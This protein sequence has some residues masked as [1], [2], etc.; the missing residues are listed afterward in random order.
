M[1]KE[2]KRLEPGQR[3]A[4][5]EVYRE[6]KPRSSQ[7]HWLRGQ[8]ASK[9]RR[10]PWRQTGEADWC[11]FVTS[12]LNPWFWTCPKPDHK[13]AILEKS[14]H[15]IYINTGHYFFFKRWW[16]IYFV[17]VF[18]K[19]SAFKIL[20]NQ[21]T[22]VK[23]STK[24]INVSKPQGGSRERDAKN[25]IDCRLCLKAFQDHLLKSLTISPKF[26]PY[27]T[28]HAYSYHKHLLTIFFHGNKYPEVKLLGNI[29]LTIQPKTANIFSRVPI[30]FYT[31]TRQTSFLG[32][33][34]SVWYCYYSSF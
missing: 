13:C 33:L 16:S 3:T 34:T 12:L 27:W 26:Q 20:F 6:D 8:R 17:P 21:L 14:I 22:K 7:T 11:H 29:K 4:L 9:N 10:S 23:H 24:K 5:E 19:L 1:Y 28:H 25:D 18:T 15:I 31:S 30:P 2:K 32:I